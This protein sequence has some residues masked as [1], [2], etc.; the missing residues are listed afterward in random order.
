MKSILAIKQLLYNPKSKYSEE[1]HLIIIIEDVFL[2]KQQEKHTS[3][4]VT[5]F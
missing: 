5:D 1:I 2:L 4:F 3:L